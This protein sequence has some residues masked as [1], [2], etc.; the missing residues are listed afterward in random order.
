VKSSV[1]GGG[2]GNLE[3]EAGGDIGYGAV[4][5]AAIDDGDVTGSCVV[6]LDVQLLMNQMSLCHCCT[7]RHRDCL[8]LIRLSGRPLAMET[9]Q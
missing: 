8:F 5:V 9:L 2:L 3:G 4:D 7:D 6:I 1:G